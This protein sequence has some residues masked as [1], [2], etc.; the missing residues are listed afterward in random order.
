MQKPVKILQA[1][2]GSGKTFSLAAHY[3]T[4][5]FSG[6]HKYREILAVTFTNKAT[7]E[8]KSRILEV[9]LGIAKGDES[10]KI[11]AY[12]QI[13]LREHPS[14]NEAKL[15]QNAHVIYRRILHDYSRFSVSTIDGFVQKV[16]RGFA[17]ELGLGSGYGL[18]M[19]IDKVKYDLS[20]QLEKSLD[21]KEN[22]LQWV[23]QLALSRINNNQS[24][25]YKRELLDLSSEVFKDR[26]KDFEI[27]I[28]GFG[29][30]N[31]DAAFKKYIDFSEGFIK[32]FEEDLITFA[33]RAENIILEGDYRTEDFKG[34]SR[35]P[36]TKF[37]AIA[38]KNFDAIASVLRLLNDEENWFQ[39][40][41]QN[42]LFES[43][44]PILSEMAEIY[45]IGFA[46]YMLAQAFLK[47]GYILRLMQEIAL[48]LS[49]YR[50]ENDTLLFSDAQKLLNGIAEDAGDNPSFIWEKM[51]NRYRNFLFD[52]FQDT[53][54]NQWS[55]FLNLVLNS[56]STHD[57]KLQD[58]LIV[59]DVKQ[60]IYRW[61]DGDYKLLHQKAKLDLQPLNVLEDH[62]EENYRST[63]EI[64]NFNNEIYPKL[65]QLLQEKINENI[66]EDG[67]FLHQFWNSESNKYG[68]VIENIYKSV[69]QKS[70]KNTRQGG[71]VKIHRID[72]SKTD[73]EDAEA[74]NKRDAALA[75]MILEMKILL[76]ERGY[77]QREIGVLVR[78]NAE[79]A[80]AVE[81]LMQAGLEVIS[82]EALKISSNIAIKLIINVLKLLVVTPINSALYKANCIALYAQIHNNPINGDHYFNL[83]EIPLSNLSN[84]LPPVFCAN[85][86]RWVQMPMPE[87]VEKIIDAFGLDNYQTGNI[88]PFLPYLLAFRDLAAK[89][90]RQGEKGISAFL[91]WWDEEGSSKNLP[92]PD[93]ANAVQVTTIHKSKGLAF[94]AVFIPFCDWKLSGRPNTT[95]WVPME[96]TPYADLQTVPLSYSSKLGGSSIAH[97]YLEETLFN[98]MDALNGLYVAT[99]RAKD[100]IYIAV[101]RKK[102]NTIT[103][104]GDALL[105]LY[106]TELEDGSDQ[107]EI[108]E[109]S[110][111][112]DELDVVD[113]ISLNNYPTSNRLEQVYKETETRPQK[114][115]TNV[116]KSARRGSNLHAVLAEANNLTEVKM[117]VDKLVLNGLIDEDEKTEYVTRATA[118]LSNPEL[119]ALLTKNANQIN[120]KAIIGI[121]G[122]TYRPDKLIVSGKQ[123]SII[124]YKFTA[125]E[126]EHHIAQIKNYKNLVEAMGYKDVKTYLFYEMKN[127]LKAV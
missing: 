66:A 9:L 98:Y 14:L 19:N 1:S 92:S 25:N 103:S 65:A 68:N 42:T 37:R 110:A 87:T 102:V 69:S 34:K 24:W 127:K 71:V 112:G 15:Q 48:L 116:T 77:Q 3:L 31:V 54:G 33:Q 95:F 115:I 76:N 27:A 80:L 81:A 72:F 117:A 96:N 120:E 82:G 114:Y 126:S 22:L 64:I 55:S 85:Y 59:G 123:V 51:G 2:A 21:E 56:I 111:V 63:E 5:L 44:N 32:K 39:K 62:L 83:N 84:V 70:H 97:H 78:T 17:L 20:S 100:F 106:K 89:A 104:I 29:S 4:L 79:A 67:E 121:D 88:N 49:A 10:K 47:N 94:R 119:S 12:K 60:S 7:E 23:I 28:K 38:A 122:K 73:T 6:E 35:S 118:V 30:E 18:E 36:L 11:D 75:D 91:T 101:A 74:E 113:S 13:I 99:T 53:S 43:L 125:E 124:D 52:E 8:M 41:K 46:D 57:G 16:I 107:I 50:E 26:F 105:S 90:S 93:A 109:F 61:R 58:H 45:N 108:G 86:R 40:G